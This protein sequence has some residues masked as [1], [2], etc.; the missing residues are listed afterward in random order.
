M[1]LY[2]VLFIPQPFW[3]GR[4]IRHPPPRSRWLPPGGAGDGG[5]TRPWHSLPFLGGYRP[6]RENVLP[7]QSH[8]AHPT[9]CRK[10]TVHFEEQERSEEEVITVPC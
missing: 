5:G 8:F 10:S 4:I 3:R 1:Y 7:E 6:E 9:N 2:D